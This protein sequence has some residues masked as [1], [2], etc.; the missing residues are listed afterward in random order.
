M[1][2]H[3]ISILGC[4]WLG[5]SLAQFLLNHD[6]K[7]KGSTTSQSN[8]SRFRDEGIEAF[9]ITL[10]EEEII[11]FVEAFLSKSETLI[12]AIPPGLRKHP[13]SNFVAKIK[14][15]I[16]YIAKSSVKNV[17]LISSTSV[18]LD[19]EYFPVTT[20]KR[21]FYA[22]TNIAKQLLET[23]QLLLSSHASFKTTV[24]RFS[25]LFDASRHPARMLSGRKGLKNPDAPVNLIHKTDC[26]H[27]IHRLIA[28]NKWGEVFHA[29]TTPH[30][31]KK[32][33]YTK[34]CQSMGIA[35]PSY[36]MQ[37]PSVGKTIVSTK[38]MDSL[39]YTFE[40]TLE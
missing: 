28:G 27:I 29:S 20:E 24:L 13:K 11:G 9:L 15:L 36:D 2:H 40:V 4:G 10:K 33:Y 6:F 25:G 37:T 8:I 18:Y 39:D 26:I 3:Q 1:K 22:D 34:I 7:I 31:K 16:P 32:D 14:Q 30:P 17:L 35:P 38:L 23:E 12:I 19:S 21:E 5:F